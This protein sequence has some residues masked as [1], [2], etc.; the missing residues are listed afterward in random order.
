MM[1]K[2]VYYFSGIL[3]L[4]IAF[5]SCNTDEIEDLFP[6]ELVEGCYI[7]NY[8]SFG[9]GGASITRYDYNADKITNFY[10]QQQNGGKELLSNIQYAC[11]HNDSIFLVGNSADQLITLN[12]LMH[13]AQNGFTE[14]MDNPRFTVADGDYLYVSCLG[15]N[16]DW[17]EMPDSYVAKVNITTNTLV[18]TFD[19]AGGPEGMVIANGKL[20]VALNYTNK[21]AVVDLT[22]KQISYIETPAVTSY[23]VKDKNDNLY[24]TL[25]STFTNF[26]TETGIG[27]INT[28]TN[29]LEETFSLENVN[30]GYG[31]VFQANGDFSKI[32]V[33]TSSYDTNWN[34]SG[35]IAE[36]D[37]ATKSFAATP[38]I[39][40]I[41]GVSGMAV[42][43]VDNNIYV[44]SGQSTTGAGLMEIYSA[45][46]NP[47]KDYA[48]GAFPVGAFFLD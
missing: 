34:L 44:F 35:G 19:I 43:P 2:N 23:F 13:Q 10:Y 5:A 41:S 28:S 17:S 42:N 30:S 18:E 48:V 26:S 27:Y 31:S 36:F 32:Y 22:S 11:V 25:V 38:L 29:Q 3:F 39:T 20:Y 40:D 46:G 8:G 6:S 9:K 12:P 1:K 33:I 16:P 45:S 37:V 14:K 15:A 47:G 21:I 7:V 24:V 4:L